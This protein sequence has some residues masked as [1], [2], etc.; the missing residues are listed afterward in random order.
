[1]NAA[2]STCTTYTRIHRSVWDCV[3]A[4]RGPDPLSPSRVR[5]WFLHGSRYGLFL[6]KQKESFNGPI[7]SSSVGRSSCTLLSVILCETWFKENRNRR[8]DGNPRATLTPQLQT[9]V[10]RGA[11][12][13]RPA[14]DPGLRSRIPSLRERRSQQVYY[15]TNQ[16]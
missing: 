9:R 6:P 16:R 4:V 13:W 1:M 3:S 7:T 14:D 5:R 10:A 11:N 8:Y 2:A 12:P 15:P